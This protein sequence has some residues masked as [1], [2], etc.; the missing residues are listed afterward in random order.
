[1]AFF[2][3][4]FSPQ[5]DFLSIVIKLEDL[6]T[7]PLIELLKGSVKIINKQQPLGK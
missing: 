3:S 5:N 2:K 1:M 4:Y 6:Y 7:L